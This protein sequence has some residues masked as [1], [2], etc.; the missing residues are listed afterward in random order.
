MEQWEKYMTN[1]VE[2]MGFSDFRVEVDTEHNHGSVF[3]YDSQNLVK[4]NLPFLIENINHLTQLVAKKQNASPIYF[5]INNYRR[6]RENLITELARQAARKVAATHQ[7]ISL[8]FM[9]SYERRLVHM[10]L[11]AHP[12]VKTE[13]VGDGKER[14]VTIKPILDD[15]AKSEPVPEKSANEESS[16]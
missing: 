12:M 13:S 6:E 14:Y 16:G 2:K 8:P 4:E 5:D 10:E 7:E 3:I 1:L 9:N 15:G 11:S